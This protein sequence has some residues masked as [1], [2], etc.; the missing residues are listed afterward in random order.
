M[1]FAT[2]L[3]ETRRATVDIHDFGGKLWLDGS[4]SDAE[5]TP[6]VDSQRSGAGLGRRDIVKMAGLAGLAA[7]LPACGKGFGGG[8]GD[9]DGKIELN[10][11]WWG[12]ARRANATQPTFDLFTAANLNVWITSE[13][14]DSTPY[15]D[16]LATRFAAGDPPDLC[17]MRLD[18]VVEYAKRG[19]LLELTQLDLSGLTDS[20]KA[21]GTV[22]GKIVGVPSGLNAIGFVVDKTLTDKYG[23]QIPDG[24]KWGWDDL[25]KFAKE[26]TTK[27]SK[28]VY[29]TN[30][31]A[32]TIANFYVFVRQL[33][34]EIFSPDGKLG[35]TTGT[36]KAWF[37]LIEGMRANGGFPPPGFVNSDGGSSASQSYL[38]QKLVASQI[39]PTNQL[40]SFNVACGGNLQLLR[41]PGET[42]AVR[43]GQS[44][45]TPALWS[46]PAKAKHPEEAVRLLD[47]I[48]NSVAAARATGTTRG[49]PASR[50]VAAAIAPSL[51][52]DDKRSSDYIVGLQA[53]ALPSQ[54]PYPVGG[55]KLVGILKSIATE[56][57]FGR[58]TPAEGAT[59]F[60]NDAGKALAG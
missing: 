30:F 55:S 41:M 48:L 27:S 33:G 47:F 36:V 59:Q 18:S 54:L 52:P 3:S 20:A 58:K 25:A 16:K 44:V 46:V 35:V 2:V 37:D 42:Q 4:R 19:S 57:E 12:D 15:K 45:D 22:D 10:V 40:E 38:A 8:G 50:K 32:F 29:G 43:R 9:R 34:E 24:N 31:E 51:S 26:V 21:L 56:V 13:Y 60:V 53:E 28:Q 7:T 5:G 6:S 23:V 11:V 1:A 39:I 49:V 14:Q 17:A